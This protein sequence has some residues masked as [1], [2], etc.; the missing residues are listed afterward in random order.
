MAS[1]PQTGERRPVPPIVLPITSRGLA[2]TDRLCWGLL[3]VAM[4]ISAGL[5]LY[6]NRGTTFFPD[7][8]NFVYSS[9]G[10]S[11]GDVFEPRNGHLVGTSQLVYAGILKIAGADYLGFRLFAVAVRLT[12]V[13]LFYALARRRI[14]ALPALAPALVLL[15]YGSAWQHVLVPVGITVV[16]CITAGLAALLALERGDRRGDVA[17]CLLLGLSLFTF[18]TGLAFLVGIAISVL[19]R[20]DRRRRAWIFL[21]PLVLYAA[22]WVWSLG[23][24]QSSQDNTTL[25]NALLIPS[26][27]ADSLAAVSAGL[28]GLAYDFTDA[29]FIDPGWGR[30]LAV[31]AVIALVLRIRRG[32]VPP[33]LWASLGIVL[34]YWALGAMAAGT[35]ARAPDALRYMYTGAVGVLLVACAAASTIRFSRLGLVA[36]F[37]AAALSIATNL[38]FLRD[39]GNQFRDGYSAPTRTQFAMIELAREHVAPEFN[40]AAA[41]PEQ[42]RAPSRAQTYLDVVDAYGS[43]AFSLAEVARQRESVRQ[44]ADDVL[45]RALDLHLEP[46]RSRPAGDCEMVTADAPGTGIAFELPPGGA[47]LRA[48]SAAPL[49]LGRFADLPTAEVGALAPD[50]T[51]TLSIPTDSSPLPWRASAEGARSMRVCPVS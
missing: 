37:A 6:L 7:E 51:S 35:T 44:F 19:L 33:L 31:L 49:T 1:V 12:S 17:A 48:D 23:L 8:L 3:G 28:A 41:F 25:S 13:G 45:A 43:P 36:L 34:T 27:M 21:V 26:W 22:W 15:F 14:G 16:T 39:G 4:A 46:T 24:D 42:A 50:Q 20:P 10:L 40:P 47:T 29:G 9:P 32:S 2:V 30:V 11:I 38:A 18:S 5:I